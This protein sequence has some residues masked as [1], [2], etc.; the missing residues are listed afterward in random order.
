VQVHWGSYVENG[1]AEE[2]NEL[3]NHVLL[4]SAQ[5]IPAGALASPLD[6]HVVE[7]VPK[8]SVEPVR[9]SDEVAL[10]LARSSTASLPPWLLLLDWLL[11]DIDLGVGVS[12]GVD[13]PDQA[14]YS[15]RTWLD[16]SG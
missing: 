16:V 5:F 6:L 8:L 4:L 12:V 15:V 10:L 14:V 7:A 9:G 13:I 2:A 3:E 11:L 1:T